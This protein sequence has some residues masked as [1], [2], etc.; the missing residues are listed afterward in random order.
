[1][2]ADPAKVNV[3]ASWEQEPASMP[4]PMSVAR[5]TKELSPALPEGGVPESMSFAAT[6]SQTGP[7][8]FAKI[9]GPLFASRRHQRGLRC[10]RH[11]RPWPD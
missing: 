5:T 4:V 10:S 7:L 11:P 1:M 8:T 9:S 2:T 6:L 3:P